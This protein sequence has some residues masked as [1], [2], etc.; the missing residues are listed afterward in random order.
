MCKCVCK[1][2]SMPTS[3]DYALTLPRSNQNEKVENEKKNLVLTSL[4][5]EKLCVL[6]GK[7]HRITFFRRHSEEFFTKLFFAIFIF[8]ECLLAGLSYEARII[9]KKCFT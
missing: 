6:V 8:F 7:T 1:N 3:R 5:P 9:V 2:I 4:W